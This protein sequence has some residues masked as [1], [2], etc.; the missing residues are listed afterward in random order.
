MY[1]EAKMAR[2]RQRGSPLR[3]SPQN[4]WALQNLCWQKTWGTAAANT[5]Q[6][7]L[8]MRRAIA[9]QVI[10]EHNQRQTYGIWSFSSSS[11]PWHCSGG[12]R[13]WRRPPKTGTW[14]HP[15]QGIC[16][17]CVCR[18]LWRA[19][20]RHAC[21][22]QWREPASRGCTCSHENVTWRLSHQG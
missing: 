22:K 20:D 5:H 21:C 7:K 15:L 17:K 11:S 12:C 4:S 16:I 14:D 1:L 2:Q 10:F 3:F 6:E 18:Q 13:P 9:Y 8:Q 19:Q